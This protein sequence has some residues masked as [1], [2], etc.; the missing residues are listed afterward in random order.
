MSRR[1]AWDASERG[2]WDAMWAGGRR[3]RTN[4]ASVAGFG[5]GRRELHVSGTGVRAASGR[6][7]TSASGETIYAST[8]SWL[9]F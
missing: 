5:A 7:G 9:P 6:P 3:V 4:A 2:V 8:L 1:G